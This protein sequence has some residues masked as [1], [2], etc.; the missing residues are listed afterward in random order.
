MN[1]FSV[2]INPPRSQFYKNL[3]R[4]PHYTTGMLSPKVCQHELVL[5][6]RCRDC[7]ETIKVKPA[8]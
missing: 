3:V 6:G 2:P 8:E 1:R 7:G 5:H 4:R